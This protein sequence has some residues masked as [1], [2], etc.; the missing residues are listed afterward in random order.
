MDNVLDRGKFDQSVRE[1][2]EKGVPLS[3]FM[4][5]IFVM[6]RG[7]LAREKQCEAE[8]LERTVKAL[9]ESLR[10]TDLIGV[11]G[12]GE[13]VV[14]MRSGGKSVGADRASWVVRKKLEAMEAECDCSIRVLT[15]A[16]RWFKGEEF[17]KMYERAI[18]NLVS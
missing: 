17:E 18:Q 4:V 15:G 6:K 5:R 3:L 8:A 9:Q 12:K 16:A 14:A 13:L 7:N 1:M 10:R 2:M 11:Y